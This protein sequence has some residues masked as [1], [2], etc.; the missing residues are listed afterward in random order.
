MKKFDIS[1]LTSPLILFVIITTL[2]TMYLFMI[3]DSV[4]LVLYLHMIV[5]S[6]LGVFSFIGF[7]VCLAK[8]CGKQLSVDVVEKEEKEENDY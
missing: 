3:R 1:Y 6:I 5:G 2:P 4:T 7:F 8:L